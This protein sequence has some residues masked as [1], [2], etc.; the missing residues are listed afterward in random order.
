MAA[1]SAHELKNSSCCSDVA[2]WECCSGFLPS[3]QESARHG[4]QVLMKYPR[5]VS[6]KFGE[7]CKSLVLSYLRQGAA[8]CRASCRGG[9]ALLREAATRKH[10]PAS[11]A[12]RC[13][14]LFLFSRK[15]YATGKQEKSI[16]YQRRNDIVCYRLAGGRS[17]EKF[18]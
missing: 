8:A 12:L 7:T 4:G 10:P 15:T 5:R 14:N 11:T 13:S 1:R 18:V 9:A 16:A 2:V 17:L 6:A 3:A